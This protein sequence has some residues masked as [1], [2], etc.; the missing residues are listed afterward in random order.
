MTQREK[1]AEHIRMA[2]SYIEEHAAEMMG[3][4]GIDYGIEIRIMIEPE[5][6]PRIETRQTIRPEGGI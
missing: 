6:W 3:T 2:A 4:C 5:S 1:L